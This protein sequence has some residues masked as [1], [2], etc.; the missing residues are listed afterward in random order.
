MIKPC[1]RNLLA[2]VSLLTAAVTALPV[3][4]QTAAPTPLLSAPT[5]LLPPP[6]AKGEPPTSASQ[7]AP[8][9]S[10]T[11]IGGIRI[12]EL[13]PI[14]T[15]A[16]SV[17]TI[18][19]LGPDLWRGTSRALIAAYLPRL[20]LPATSP[21]VRDLSHSLLLTSA[22]PP[23]AEAKSAESLLALRLDRLAA[24]GDADDFIALAR[25]VPDGT[26]VVS[27]RARVEAG[28]LAGDDGAAC[29]EVSAPDRNASFRGEF[30]THAE[31]VCDLLAKRTAQAQL[32]LD[33]M[34]E[35]GTTDTPFTELLHVVLGDRKPV[36]NLAGAGP[37]EVA[38]LRLSKAEVAPEAL[39][40]AS[41]LA[42]RA[43]ALGDAAL[44]VR[45]DAAERAEAIGAIPTAT[46]AG[47][48]AAVPFKKDELTN[49]LTLAG[50]DR[51]PRGRALFFK[52]ERQAKGVPAANAEILKAALDSAR[53]EGCLAQATRIYAADIAAIEPAPELLWFAADAARALYV[54]GSAPRADAWRALALRG[55]DGDTVDASL[56][57]LSTIAWVTSSTAVATADGRAVTPAWNFRGFSTAGFNR[58]L[59]SLPES[60]RTRKG[61]LAL[62]LFD[63]L[64]AAV[65]PESWGPFLDSPSAVRSSPLLA[66]LGRA[67]QAGR[68]GETVLLAL[69]ALGSGDPDAWAPETTA[70]AVTAL[71]KINLGTD[72]R[73]LAIDAATAAGL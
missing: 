21:A 17:G 38:L 31:M 63:S 52:A 55:P 60:D 64:G 34:G 58:W 4:G 5:P 18:D 16:D 62:A 6:R 69:T 24:M 11:A 48:Y 15:Q 22:V 37:L 51:S 70:A 71:V 44:P 68:V 46:L 12:D 61:A 9:S 19:G 53:E 72:A 2:T 14:A 27:A 30:W 42:L 25:A 28:F 45:L 50:N 1:I 73:T 40:G 3:V 20:P 67:A 66:P 35:Q 39:P 57:P 47:T 10:E 32:A 29:A 33:L 36:T 56:W 26:D 43:V 23:P 65:P 7:P 49:A 13:G 41:A 59:A 8:A 54:A